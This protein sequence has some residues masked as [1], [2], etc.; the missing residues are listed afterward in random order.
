MFIT[1]KKLEELLTAERKR[2][3]EKHRQDRAVDNFYRD[4][5]DMEKR[6][7]ER[8]ERIERL[9]ERVIPKEEREKR[10]PF[11]PTHRV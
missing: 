1:K 9:A 5:A 7:T 11:E 10:C 3:F 8:I 6:L 4:I 2:C